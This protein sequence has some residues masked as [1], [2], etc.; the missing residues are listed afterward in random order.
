MIPAAR[1]AA[2][3]E[4]LASID[5]TRGPAAQALK[6][7]GVAHRFAGS[8]DRAAISGLVYDT[9]RRRA[10]SA[11]LLGED[12][13]RA[14]VFGML[15]LERG[16]GADA[17]AKLCSGERHAPEPL[18]ER[19][20]AALSTATLDGAPP[21]IAGDYPEWLDGAF[22]RAFGDQ[23]VAEAIAMAHRAPLDLRVNTLSAERDKVL[24]S[25][26]H[27]RAQPTPWSPIGLRILLDAD[28]R[29]PGIQAEPDFIKGS[30]E[31]QDEGSQ[32]AALFADA[33]ECE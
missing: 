12:S 10:S 3:I 5:A 30:I 8:G 27:L 18:T 20:R 21:H 24:A 17:I 31:V 1:I 2:A 32:L 26:R 6:E 7:W 29:S 22:R 13:A 15:K 11:F 9:L 28:A 14:R 23:R 25:L 33:R 4:V 19:E 16:L